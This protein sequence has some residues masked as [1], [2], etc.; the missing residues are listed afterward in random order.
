MNVWNGIAAVAA[1]A[2]AAV[3]VVK[4]IDTAGTDIAAEREHRARQ[5]E[6]RR[7]ERREARR[8]NTERLEMLR[9]APLPE[10]PAERVIDRVVGAIQRTGK[11]GEAP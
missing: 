11:G 3:V 9:T 6:L 5:E 4:C 7:E 2:A 10:H 1:L 8:E